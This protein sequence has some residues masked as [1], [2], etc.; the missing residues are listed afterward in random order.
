MIAGYI[1]QERHS[2]RLRLARRDTRLSGGWGEV[3]LFSA[4]ALLLVTI[5]AMTPADTIGGFLT[6]RWGLWAGLLGAS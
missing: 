4:C 2:L 5:E 3:V 6:S 1:W